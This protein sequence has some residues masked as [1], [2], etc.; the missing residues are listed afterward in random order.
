[1]GTRQVLRA[2]REGRTGQVFLADDADEY[3][4]RQVTEACRQAGAQVI[5]V[6]SMAELGAACNIQ[7][8]AAVACALQNK[9][10]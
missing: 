3:I 5:G 4:R 10:D 9:D 6:A 2:L 7:V 1:V 8:P